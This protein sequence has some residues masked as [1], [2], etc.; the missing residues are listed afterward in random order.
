MGQKK[1]VWRILDDREL[2]QTIHLVCSDDL[3]LTKSIVDSICDLVKTETYQFG[4]RF[5]QAKDII[6]CLNG[7]LHYVNDA[8]SLMPHNRESFCTT[9]IPVAYDPSAIAPKFMKFLHEIFFGDDDAEQKAILIC[10]L[11][12]YTLLPTCRYE[13]FALL[14]G[15]GANG[16]SVLLSLVGA[17]VG[18]ENVCA[19]QPSQFENRFQRANLHGKLVN[20][21]TEIAEGAEIADAQ[22]KAIVSG[23]LTTAEHKHKSPF[24]FEPF[25]T[26]WFG[27]NHLPH[28]RDFSDAL[29]RRAIPIRFN[30]KFEGANCNPC[31]KEELLT[32]LSGIMNLALEA[33]AGV[34]Q[35]GTFTV[36][37]SSEF[38][39]RQWRNEADQASQLLEEAC[40]LGPGKKELSSHVWQKY[41]Q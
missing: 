18:R 23:E 33:I 3:D 32:E 21:I 6:N 5:N 13:K 25:C 27:T 38:E 34:F 10:E 29:F 31:Q 8:W 14:I 41:Q 35:R 7:E 37:K 11:I 26:C 36:P 24:D 2:K 1:G 16:K 12:G 20:L 9:Q 40:E 17:I 22:L 15:N 19:V 30:R 39:K 28:T 4:V